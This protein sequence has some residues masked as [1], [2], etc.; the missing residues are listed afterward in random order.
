MFAKITL[1][2]EKTLW[3]ALVD[4][5]KRKQLLPV[6]SFTFSRNK[7]DKNAE[8][9]RSLDLTTGQE[10]SLIQSFFNRSISTLKEPDRQIPQIIKMQDILRRGIGVHHSGVL[11][12]IKEIVEILFQSGL[13][14]VCSK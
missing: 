2:Q 12:I 10:K 3:Y 8:N 5:L 1:K 7:C 4:H 6:V 11:P 13:V 14:K 9:L